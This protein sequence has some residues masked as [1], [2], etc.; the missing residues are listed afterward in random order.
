M[1]LYVRGWSGDAI[2]KKIY[3][4][5]G[6][7]KKKIRRKN[8]IFEIKL[9]ILICIYFQVLFIYGLMTATTLR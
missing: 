7:R 2:A 5:E 8:R 6:K 4:I 9:F 1:N 3:R